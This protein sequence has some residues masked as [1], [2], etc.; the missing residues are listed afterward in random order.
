MNAKELEALLNSRAAKVRPELSAIVQATEDQHLRERLAQKLRIRTG[1]RLPSQGGTH[2]MP[3]TRKAANFSPERAAQALSVLVH[4]GKLKLRDITKA[5]DRREK[6][7]R[8][9]RERLASLGE[10]VSGAASRI[11]RRGRRKAGART[12][13][14]ATKPRRI[15]KAQR[16]ARQA[17]GRY[18]GAIRQLPAE[19]RAKVKEIRAKSG[20]RAAIAAAKR[21]GKK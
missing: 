11:A 3:R 20:V 7:I 1:D 9:L 10:E 5:L 16:A 2:P 8:E 12:R 13:K 4:E 18:L 15:S 6:M 14:V 17:Q 21:M 19:A